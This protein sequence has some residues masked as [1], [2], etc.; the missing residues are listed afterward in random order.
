MP[1][2]RQRGL[3]TVMREAIERA[4]D[5]CDAVYATYDIDVIDV[6]HAPGNGGIMF[7][8]LTNSEGF[9]VADMLAGCEE[10]PRSMSSKST[11]TTMCRTSRR[12]LQRLLCSSF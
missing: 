4:C 7:G 9:V 2:I 1:V 5:G 3:E 12:S 10:S 6:I 8:G 11:R